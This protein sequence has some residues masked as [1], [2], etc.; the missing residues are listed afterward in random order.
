MSVRVLGSVLRDSEATM[1]KRLVLIALAD[2]AG[3]DG[4]AWP[5]HETVARAARL[6]RTHTLRL[7]GELADEGLVEVRKTRGQRRSNVYRVLAPDLA[8]VDYARLPFELDAPFAA[9]SEVTTSEVTTSYPRSGD[10][11]SAQVATSDPP[12]RVNGTVNRNRKGNRDP[13]APSAP[14]VFAA[15]VARR[16]VTVGEHRLADAVLAEFNRVFDT[17]FTLGAWGAKVVMR[18]REHPELGLDEHRAVIEANARDPWWDGPASPSVVYGNAP[19]F[20]RA[21]LAGQ[22]K[23][24]LT[25]ADVAE[26]AMRM[27][28]DPGEEG[29]A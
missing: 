1:G 8:E 27:G 2:H 13:V 15:T 16:P 26:I 21:M 9:T 3:D 7:L 25:A 22:G 14:A 18:L 10:V 28:D 19:L 11:R 24:K 4:V 5:H 20:E 29:A 6:S 17:R 23:R 12:S